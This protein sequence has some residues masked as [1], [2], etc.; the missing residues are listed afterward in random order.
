MPNDK[1]QTNYTLLYR[2][3]H[4]GD[5][6]AW[7]E[8]YNRYTAFV[9][10]ILNSIGVSEADMD[11]ISQEVF[12]ELSAKFKHYDKE[13]GRFRGWLAGF[14]RFTALR[15][16]RK[17]VTYQKYVDK[18]GEDAAVFEKLETSDIETLVEKEWSKYVIA[19][20]AERLT[21]KYRGKAATVFKLWMEGK[22]NTEIAEQVEVKI[23]TVYTFKKRIKKTL[24]EEAESIRAELDL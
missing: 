16:L 11:D 15:H 5:Q 2:S 20:A 10:H 22:D 12:I 23:S 4:L 18:S 17:K 6:E 24:Y 1:N 7:E 21:S 3:L 14:I 9:Y 19:I 13:K 8:L